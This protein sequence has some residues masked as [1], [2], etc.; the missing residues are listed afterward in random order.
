MCLFAWDCSCAESGIVIKTAAE[1]IFR[2]FRENCP[3][4][5][6]LFGSRAAAESEPMLYAQLVRASGSFT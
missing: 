3:Q 1:L 2:A 5:Y 4:A 6:S